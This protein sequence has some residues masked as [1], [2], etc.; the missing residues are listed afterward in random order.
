M[1]AN[2]QPTLWTSQDGTAGSVPHKDAWVVQRLADG[3]T[4]GRSRPCRVLPTT[5]MS[6]IWGMDVDKDSISG[7]I[8]NPGG[9]SPD[10]ERVTEGLGSLLRIGRC[11]GLVHLADVRDHGQ[12]SAVAVLAVGD[13]ELG[14]HV[15]HVRLDGALADEKALR[16]AGVGETFGH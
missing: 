2:S 13:V 11:S 1:T 8:L 4:T 5:L 10:L 12:H 7:G 3:A 6:S 9:D 15:P 16:D 14:E